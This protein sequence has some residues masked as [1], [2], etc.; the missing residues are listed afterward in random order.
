MFPV[1]VAAMPVLEAQFVLPPIGL[2]LLLIDDDPVLLKSLAEALAADGHLISSADG[3]QAGIDA[4][5]RELAQGRVFDAVITDLGMPA[6]SGREVVAA[7]KQVSPSTRVFLLTGWGRHMEDEL[8]LSSQVDCVLSK[9]PKMKELR[10]A[11]ARYCG[12]STEAGP[13]APDRDPV[14]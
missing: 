10:Q 11:F 1:G 3:G 7:I 6:V 5:N 12:D 4:F 2:R 8:E 13:N 9:P 14:L